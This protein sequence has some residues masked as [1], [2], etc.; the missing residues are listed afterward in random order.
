[1]FKLQAF[2]M[3]LKSSALRV[4]LFVWLAALAP[5]LAHAGTIEIHSFFKGVPV[6][7]SFDSDEQFIP[8]GFGSVVM[9]NPQGLG[10]LDAVAAFEAYCVEMFG[11]I[12]L[13]GSSTDPPGPVFGGADFP[14]GVFVTVPAN[15]DAMTNWS[16]A[17]IG[18]AG[19]GDKAARLYATYNP[20]I[21][22]QTSVSFSST[23][24]V[25]ADVARTA[26]SM[27]IWETL[28]EDASTYG[29]DDG[30]G[31]FFVYCDSTSPG[32]CSNRPQGLVVTL[33]NQ[34]LNSLGTISGEA[35]WLQL[36]DA[37]EDIQDF[38]GPSSATVPEPASLT[39]VATGLVAVIVRAR[40]RTRS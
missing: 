37:A 12:F 3:P 21:Q 40:A 25:S 9:R 39:L 26:L 38:I 8:E 11:D 5:R 6:G 31:T 24:T 32:P 18:V 4:L 30:N 22:F 2:H 35:S 1:M 16:D 23:G 36:G 14:P 29:V 28:Y 15:A 19:G 27:A 10:E 17:P 13:P 33:A 7:V 34:F 20:L